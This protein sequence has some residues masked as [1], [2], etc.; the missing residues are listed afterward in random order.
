MAKSLGQ[1][2]TV[3]RSINTGAGVAPTNHAIDLPSALTSQ[4][5]RMVR[6]G[7]F[8]KIV[9]ID[10][11]LD[12]FPGSAPTGSVSGRF[13]YY[14]PTRGRCAA[15]RGAFKAMA[16]TMKLQGLTMRDNPMYDFTVPL[17]DETTAHRNQA[18]LN[19]VDGLALNHSIPAQSVFAVHNS[20]VQPQYSG[21]AG[22]LFNSG[23]STL[24][25]AGNPNIDFVL[26]DAIP[27]EGNPNVASEDFEQIPFVISW[28]ATGSQTE[29]TFQW[30]PD[31]ALY[32]AILC[33][34]L[35]MIIDEK[36]TTAAF[37]INVS[38][39]VSGWKS[40]MGSP[41]KKPRRRMK[42]KTSGKKKE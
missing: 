22:D 21:T 23:F 39:M 29:I 30:R 1:I 19:G 3:N 33:G 31:P 4:L 35:R 6:A 38:I 14:A 16:N 5:N 7:N 27:F 37:N 32:L 17:D 36:T 12:S 41:D 8:F 26:N 42:S 13:L 24:Q 20:N 10:M 18:S 15:F 28:D 40:I 2:H 11:T 9:G 34:Q 25:N